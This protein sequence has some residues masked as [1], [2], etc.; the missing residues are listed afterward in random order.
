MQPVT[1]NNTQ[2]NDWASFPLYVVFFQQTSGIVR[3]P[4]THLCNVSLTARAARYYAGEQFRLEK[5]T[6]LIVDHIFK[7][8]TLTESA[9]ENSLMS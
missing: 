1:H 7:V 3:L 9:T 6:E 5:R 2:L 8:L 4:L